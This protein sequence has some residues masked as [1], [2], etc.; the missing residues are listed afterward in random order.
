MSV[1]SDS[2]SSS[3]WISDN[4]PEDLSTI[5]GRQWLIYNKRT[6]RAENRIKN[7][8]SKV[9]DNCTTVYVL[10]WTGLRCWTWRCRKLSTPASKGPS[11]R[12][13]KI[14]WK[15]GGGMFFF[16]IFK[17]LCVIGSVQYFCINKCIIKYNVCLYVEI[18]K[19]ARVFRT[20]RKKGYFYLIIKKLF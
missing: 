13:E 6:G 14:K 8:G 11:P 16:Y 10:L 20:S 4:L 18:W 7:R 19:W 5:D 15:K 9:S 1:F 3:T 2:D 17:D 12:Q